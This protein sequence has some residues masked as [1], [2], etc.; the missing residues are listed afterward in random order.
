[1][2][3]TNFLSD[4][5]A[6]RLEPGAELD[7][8]GGGRVLIISDL[9][10]GT[11]KRDDLARNGDLLTA[12]LRNYYFEQGWHL[13]LNG[14]IEDIHRHPLDRIEERWADLCRVFGLF[15]EQ[16]R[17]F[18]LVGNHDEGLLLRRSY[19][20]PLYEMI[21]IETG[22]IPAYVYHGHQSSKIY[23]AFNRL[24]GLGIRYFMA[25]FGIM[26]ISSS[27]S[28]HRRFTVEKAAYDFSLKKNC[29]SIIGH[30]H[31]PLFESLGRFEYVRFE[32]ENLCRKY[33]LSS[34][35]EQT[36]IEAE[37]ASLRRELGKLKRKERRDMLRRSFSLYGDEMPVPCLFNSGC[38][39][40][41]KG[42]HGI[43]LSARDISL[44]YWFAEGKSKK[45]VHRG[46]Y[47]IEKLGESGYSRAVL[48]SERLDSVLARIKLLA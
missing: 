45:F 9:H 13:V 19:R 34:E 43:E 5:L 18:K 24:M 37:V 7:I 12:L 17:L 23:S 6:H 31:R 28:P 33:S 16:G 1:M 27:R 4:I 38:A 46:G 21:R 42:L 29:I 14:D 20:F 44:V 40:G 15:A 35:R 39:I 2:A 36:Q 25:P 22:V 30:T 3:Q 26:N 48:N 8:S 11:G 32:I 47:D 41:K 10:M